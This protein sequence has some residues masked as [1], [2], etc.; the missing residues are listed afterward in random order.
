MAKTRTFSCG[1]SAV[2][3]ADVSVDSGFWVDAQ[4]SS[5][6]S[7]SKAVQTMGS[8]VACAR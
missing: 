7:I 4:M 3:A 6:S 2:A 5:L 8:M 1:T